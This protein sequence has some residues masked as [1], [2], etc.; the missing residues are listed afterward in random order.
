MDGFVR[1]HM[2]LLDRVSGVVV[3]V[4]GTGENKGRW[5]AWGKKLLTIFLEAVR[6]DEI[7]RRFELR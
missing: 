3:P 5:G 6:R 2:P 4:L 1:H 7:H